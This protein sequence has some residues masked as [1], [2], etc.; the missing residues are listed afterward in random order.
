MTY[1]NT[2][3]SNDVPMEYM[4]KDGIVRW[5]SNGR[6]PFADVLETLF[7]NLCITAIE[8]IE[9]NKARELETMAI[10]ESYREMQKNAPVSNE[11]HMSELRANFEPGTV[12]VDVITGRKVT[13]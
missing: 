10:I 9:S 2:F 13:V 1:T 5:T 7:K 12:V 3:V 8:M 6:V 11:E 4:I